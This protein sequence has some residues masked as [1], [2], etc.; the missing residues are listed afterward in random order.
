MG[1]PRL[2]PD[3]ANLLRHSLKL[4]LPIASAISLVLLPMI[5]LYESSRRDM[6]LARVEG[7]LQAATVR[8]QFTLREATADSG[9]MRTLPLVL[10]LLSTDSPS[11][12]KRQR[13]EMMMRSQMREH[14]RFRGLMVLG[15]HGQP[16]VQV[17]RGGPPPSLS[18]LREAQNRASSLPEV[19]C[20]CRRCSGR[21]MGSRNCWWLGPCL[22][23]RASGGVCSSSWSPCRG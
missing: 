14:E 17:V 11:P 19:R 18:I 23:T 1:R 16:R 10:E 20:G 22:T 15:V 21:R 7:V 12:L 8:V 4:F 9:V 2:P 13:V 3:T 6:V 5:G